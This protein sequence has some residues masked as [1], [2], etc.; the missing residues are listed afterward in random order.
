MKLARFLFLL[1][2]LLCSCSAN[3]TNGK[4]SITYVDWKVLEQQCSYQIPYSADVL[5]N[6]KPSLFTDENY[7]SEERHYTFVNGECS[8]S[9]NLS[10]FILLR[11]DTLDKNNYSSEVYNITYY[12]DLSV[13]ISASISDKA[14]GIKLIVHE[15][16]SYKIHPSGY[17]MYINMYQ[18]IGVSVGDQGQSGSAR[19]TA[20]ITYN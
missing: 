8:P 12:N 3:K 20:K 18:R 5:F 11:A 14:Y 4:K 13:S 16:V 17:I 6:G 7:K 15:S 9:D 2:I 1:P 10:Q 19:F